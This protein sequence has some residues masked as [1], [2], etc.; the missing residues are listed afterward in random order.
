[1]KDL[2][3]EICQAKSL[4]PEAY[5]YD[6]IYNFKHILSTWYWYRVNLAW[7]TVGN[8][9]A[10][11]SFIQLMAWYHRLFSEIMLTIYASTPW[12][13]GY[14]YSC[15]S[16]R[17]SIPSLC[18]VVDTS[19]VCLYIKSSPHGQNGRHFTDDIFRC[20]FVNQNFCILIEISLKGPIDN[21]LALV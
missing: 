11:S 6:L 7:M 18:D 8:S 20:I 16:K 3:D 4:S 19:N 9:N 17:A 21:N 5:D 13:C 10:Q 2:W 14:T 1:M 12:C 15:T